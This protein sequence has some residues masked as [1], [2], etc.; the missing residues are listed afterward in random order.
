[1]KRNILILLLSLFPLLSFGQGRVEFEGIRLGQDYRT[2]T[3]QLKSR[4]FTL[5]LEREGEDSFFYGVCREGFFVGKVDGNPAAVK[6][7]AS[8]KTDTVFSVEANLREFIDEAEALEEA[9]RLIPREA[10]KV[11][12]CK[13]ETTG[14]NMV[15]IIEMPG[16]DKHLTKYMCYP[17]GCLLLRFYD[18]Q[19]KLAAKDSY[20]MED[21]EVYENPLH[22]EY[23]IHIRYHDAAAARIAEDESGKDHSW[24]DAK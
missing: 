17:V 15:S 8:R 18:S 13:N 22:R 24:R 19:Q 14:S 2:F 6:V 23:I 5:H 11:P 4:G 1:M 21:F 9:N 12:V 20:G 16:G 7:I 10:A 3:R